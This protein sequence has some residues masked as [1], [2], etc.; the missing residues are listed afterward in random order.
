MAIASAAK[1]MAASELWKRA[2]VKSAGRSLVDSLG[3]GDEDTRQV[4]GML[5]VKGGRKSVPLIREAIDKRQHLESVLLIAADLGDPGLASRI[6]AFTDDPD[7][8]VARA[9]RDAVAIVEEH[10][11]EQSRK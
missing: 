8:E 6:P 11:R 4:A 5:L 1:L 10:A 3:S 2:R 7:P 9:A